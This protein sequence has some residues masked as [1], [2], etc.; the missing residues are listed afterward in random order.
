MASCRSPS[1]WCFQ[2]T[3]PL[4][5]EAQYSSLAI[6]F[7]ATTVCIALDVEVSNVEWL[8]NQQEGRKYLGD[9]Y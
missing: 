8:S 1:Y 5:T 4:K 3:N 2:M 9:R 7:L 6:H